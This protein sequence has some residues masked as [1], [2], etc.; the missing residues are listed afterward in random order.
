MSIW[1]SP[2]LDDRSLL[3]RRSGLAPAAI[4]ATLAF[5]LLALV[6]D[7]AVAAPDKDLTS[8]FWQFRQ[9]ELDTSRSAPVSQMTIKREGMTLVLESGRIWLAQPF[10]DRITGAYFVGDATVTMTAHGLAGRQML[11]AT[12]SGK[13]QGVSFP[14]SISSKVIVRPGPG[15]KNFDVFAAK[16]H[17]VW[18]RFSDGLEETIEPLMQDGG[19]EGAAAA[20]KKFAARTLNFANVPPDEMEMINLE[21]DF[22]IQVENGIDEY[23]FFIA[24]FDLG[25]RWLTY[26]EFGGRPQEVWIG[27]HETVSGIQ[28]DGLTWTGYD[29]AAE[30]D[31]GGHWDGD[32]EADTKALLDVNDVTMD[33]DLQ[34][35]DAIRIDAKITFTPR[36]QPL[37]LVPFNFINNLPPY[38]WND[39]KGHPVHLESVT[40]A[41]GNELP[42]LHTRDVV[43][44]RLR[45]PAA[46]GEATALRFKAAE[47]ILTQVSRQSWTIVNTFDWFPR[48]GY[49]GGRYTTDWTIRVKK[50]LTAI[51]SGDLLDSREEGGANVTHWASKT[52]IVFPSLIFG[53]FQSK[54][55]T[56]ER[57]TGKPVTIGVYANPL[58]DFRGTTKTKSILEESKTIMKLFETLY[59]PFPYDRLDITQMAPFIGFGQAPPGILFLTGDAFLPT[60]KVA[61]LLTRFNQGSGQGAGREGNLRSPYYHDFFAHELGHQWWG[62]RVVWARDED[63]WLSEAFTEYAAGLYAMQIDGDKKFQDKL[64]RWRDGAKDG[65][66]F[67]FPIAAANL[68]RHKTAL[69]AGKA[70]TNLI[71]NKGAYVVHMLRMT[72]GHDK[73]VEAMQRFLKE[74]DGQMATTRML[75]KDVEAVV[76][77]SMDWFFDQWFYLNGEPTFRFSYDVKKAEDG[78]YVLTGRIVQDDAAHFKQVLMP[79]FYDLGGKN[80]VVRNQVVLKANH[81]FQIK[82]PSKPKRVWLDGFHT[83]LGTII[84]E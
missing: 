25:P 22:F 72:I 30:Y 44:V 29:R 41:E 31:K 68:V 20:A 60:G 50:P 70:R 48:H 37:A 43:L 58:G 78:G 11:R 17:D 27:T 38:W 13:N 65:D 1:F 15:E 9:V 35:T 80:P 81:E 62:H 82:L 33:I 49:L 53:R 18:L 5:C 40:D 46:P 75:M 10:L 77:G 57:L 36:A 24:E 23:A 54:E 69:V 26:A 79:V 19:G 47:E 63:Q 21:N 52:P 45:R 76:G 7:P 32:V 51:A 14:G 61:E 64:N 84:K 28:Q 39:Q 55:G 16:V 66:E 2:S 4:L 12:L 59:G 73:Y 56:Y 42:F 3:V 34:S 71:Y 83:I 8:A 6:P 67:G 74:H